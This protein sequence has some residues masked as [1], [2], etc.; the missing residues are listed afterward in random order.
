MEKNLFRN[1]VQSLEEASAIA[2]GEALASRRIKVA[3]LPDVRVIR[4]RA[5]LSQSEL[6]RLM[7]VSVRTIQRWE[8]YRRKPTGPAIVLLKILQVAPDAA[9]EVLRI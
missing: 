6:A 1:L 4:E 8:V 9:I 7:R 5:G 3:P 2:K